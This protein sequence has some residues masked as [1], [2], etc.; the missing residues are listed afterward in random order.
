MIN[1]N[2]IDKAW[3][4]RLTKE[5]WTKDELKNFG[6][7]CNGDSVRTRFGIGQPER[8]Q[9]MDVRKVAKLGKFKQQKRI[10]AVQMGTTFDDTSLK[11]S[12]WSEVPPSPRAANEKLIWKSNLHSKN[13]KVR[14]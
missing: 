6:S 12:T 8:Q 10:A 7:Y 4:Q 11:G 3:T 14:G 1:Y 5:I 13:Q 2:D 9:E